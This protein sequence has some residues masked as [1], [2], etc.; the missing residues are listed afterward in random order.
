MAPERDTLSVNQ[1]SAE[2]RLNVARQMRR[3]PH[4]SLGAISRADLAQ[5]GFDMHLDSGFSHIK[6]A[7]N[8]LIGRTLSEAVEDLR[9]A[10]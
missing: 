8:D 10:I 9:L 3:S 2:G 4:S 7:G 6:L 1:L 5:E